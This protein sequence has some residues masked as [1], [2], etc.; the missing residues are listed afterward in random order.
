MIGSRSADLIVQV[1]C[2][3]DGGG[4]F[5]PDAAVDSALAV[6][7]SVTN[8]DRMEAPGIVAPQGQNGG[9]MK[10]WELETSVRGCDS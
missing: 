10:R 2:E 4:G 7:E 8:S 5:T 6:I 3:P 9:M 1:L